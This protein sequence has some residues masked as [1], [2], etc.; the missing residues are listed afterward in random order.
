[1]GR[2][3]ILACDNCIPGDASGWYVPL[4]LGMLAALLLAAGCARVAGRRDGARST[5]ALVAAVALVVVPF[6]AVLALSVDPGRGNVVCGSAL[7]SSLERGLPND[8]ALDAGQTYCKTRGMAIRRGAGTAVAASLVGAALLVGW[9]SL[10]PR[11]RTAL[12]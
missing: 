1:V 8:A 9:S 11:R 6:G 4:T 10:P 2:H 7:S 3:L 5:A 12:A